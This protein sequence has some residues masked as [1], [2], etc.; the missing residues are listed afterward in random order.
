MPVFMSTLRR[1]IG[2]MVRH[3][4]ELADLTQA[5][6]GEKVGKAL[7]S[8]GRIE[9]GEVAPSI[10]TLEELAGALNVELR[11]FFGAGTFAV[12]GGRADPL[13]RV[14]DRLSNLSVEDLEWADKMLALALSR[15]AR[16]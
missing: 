4:R 11:D 3:H 16:S 7:E 8:I 1:Q 6:L 5:E 15:K 12:K 2:A 14:I 10:K 13:V 9:R